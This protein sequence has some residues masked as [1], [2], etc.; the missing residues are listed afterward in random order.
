MGGATPG[1][2]RRGGVAGVRGWMKEEI[3]TVGS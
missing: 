1:D 2:G 3:D